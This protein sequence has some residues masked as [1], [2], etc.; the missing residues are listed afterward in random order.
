MWIFCLFCF[1]FS[2]RKGR[3]NAATMACVDCKGTIA[4]Q[5]MFCK[6]RKAGLC[7]SSKGEQQK[8]LKSTVLFD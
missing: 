4:S 1:A 7:P 5:S 6:L 3:V 2:L 8:T